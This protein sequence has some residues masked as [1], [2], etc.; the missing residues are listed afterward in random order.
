M[1]TRTLVWQTYLAWKEPSLDDQFHSW[2]L[3]FIDELNSF[4]E[5]KDAGNPFIYLDY[6]YK[7]QDPLASYG[8][9]NLKK[10]KEV[11][12]KYDPEEVFQIMVPGGF[13][14][15][16]AGEGEGE[17]GEK[18]GNGGKVQARKDGKMRKHKKREL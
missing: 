1:L 2:G 14:L 6:A 7:S 17:G 16:R 13:K 8:E 11:A 4:A 12:K 9:E 3:E 15:S 5:S 10:M 18:A